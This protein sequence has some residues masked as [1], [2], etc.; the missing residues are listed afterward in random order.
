MRKEKIRWYRVIFIGHAISLLGVMNTLRR[1]WLEKGRGGEKKIL[2]RVYNTEPV[3]VVVVLSSF[4]AFQKLQKKKKG[5]K[6]TENENKT[7]KKEQSTVQRIMCFYR[8]VG[9]GL[10]EDR[11]TE[12]ENELHFTE[13][14][15]FL[16][17]NNATRTREI[18]ITFYSL[19]SFAF[20]TSCTLLYL[21]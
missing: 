13:T 20:S 9:V 17:W 4:F 11:E 1:S 5:E 2:S 8:S 18:V 15:S 14:K 7:K 16:E 6:K 12:K 21:P 3:I 19:I 10:G